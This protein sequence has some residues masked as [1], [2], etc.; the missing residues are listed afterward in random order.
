MFWSAVLVLTG[1]QL[2]HEATHSNLWDTEKL[3]SC[4]VLTTRYSLVKDLVS[5]HLQEFILLVKIFF[6]IKKCQKMAQYFFFFFI[7][8]SFSSVLGNTHHHSCTKTMLPSALSPES[9]LLF[10]VRSFLLQS[11]S[12]S[13]LFYSSCHPEQQT[14]NLTITKPKQIKQTKISPSLFPG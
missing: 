11:G 13:F 5:W 4:W 3:F 14:L 8:N 1:L 12:K 7:L 10:F 2:S 9:P 6:P